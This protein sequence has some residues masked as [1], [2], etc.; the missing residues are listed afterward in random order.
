MENYQQ[1]DGTIVVPAVLRP[2]MNGLEVIGKRK[3]FVSSKGGKAPAEAV[4][5]TDEINKAFWE[6]SV[7][8]FKIEHTLNPQEVNPVEYIAV[9]YAGGHGVMWD[10]PNNQDLGRIAQTI[11]ENG[12]VVS[13]VCHAPA[14]LL[15]VKLSN[16]ELLIKGKKINSFTNEEEKF[17]N[18][19]SLIQIQ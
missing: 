14:A 9:F 17:L 1:E 11:Y 10:Y 3:N 5:L 19:N 7:Y 16:G 18:T 6:N 4:D 12:G 13:A 15:N 8:R 2:Y